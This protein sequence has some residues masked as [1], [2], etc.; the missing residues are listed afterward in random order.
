MS[1]DFSIALHF[2]HGFTNKK[3]AK[4]NNAQLKRRIMSDYKKYA[5]DVCGHVYDEAEGDP[6]SGI[7]PGTRWQDVPEDW[8]CP[9]CGA[10]KGR[11]MLLDE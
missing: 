3:L 9:E 4:I 6:V 11:F 5:C 8:R 7:S 10:S 1:M 2:F